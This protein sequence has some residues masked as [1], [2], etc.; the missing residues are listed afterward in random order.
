M[1]LGRLPTKELGTLIELFLDDEEDS[2]TLVVL[3]AL[4]PSVKRGYMTLSELKTLCRWKSPRA[5]ALV[6][7]NSAYLVRRRTGTAF[8]SRSERQKL[9]ALTDL[10]GVSVPMASAVLTL[11]SPKR[12]G[13]IDIRVWQ[14]LGRTGSVSRHPNGTG[15]DFR[16][17]YRYL[18]I[19]RHHA[20]RLGVPVCDVERTLFLI[21]KKHQTGALYE[22]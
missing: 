13:V 7:R 18:M 20:T 10:Q 15:F 11:T 3:R 16:D 19:L 17:W 6:S 4:R 8:S 14:V 21:H 2:D 9:A 5:I 12:Y 22:K 1:P